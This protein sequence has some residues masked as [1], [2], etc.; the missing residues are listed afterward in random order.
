MAEQPI[1][2]ISPQR[3]ALVVAIQARRVDPAK[4]AGMKADILASAGRYPD[5][6]VVVDFSQVEF[7]SSAG[8]GAFVALSQTIRKAGRRF[9]LGGMQ[10]H[11]RSAF[12]VS[13]LDTKLE[14]VDDLDAFVD[15]P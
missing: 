6:H 4:L 12:A 7:L 10:R 3:K 8:M 2:E 13:R 14:I 9:V 11:M 5:R 15:G 1:I